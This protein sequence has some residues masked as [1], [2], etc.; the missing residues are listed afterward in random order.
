MV[1]LRD[2]SV[3]LEA[4]SQHPFGPLDGVGLKLLCLKTVLPLALL[5][6]KG[7]S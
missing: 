3:V 4:L 6:A 5:T 7:S 1:L 2:L